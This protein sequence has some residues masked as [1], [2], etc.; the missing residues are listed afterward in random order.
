MRVDR[1]EWREEVCVLG[2]FPKVHVEISRR[3]EI[4]R[5]LVICACL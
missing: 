1:R 2:G 4:S 3:V 5:Q